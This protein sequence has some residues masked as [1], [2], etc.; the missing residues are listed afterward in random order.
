MIRNKI[1]NNKVKKGC[2]TIY[3]EDDERGT[4]KFDKH[5]EVDFKRRHANLYLVKYLKWTPRYVNPLGVVIESIPAKLMNNYLDFRKDFCNVINVATEEEKIFIQQEV[6]LLLQTMSDNVET[7]TE[8]EVNATLETKTDTLN[9]NQEMHKVKIKTAKMKVE[10]GK[11]M[12]KDLECNENS[13]KVTIEPAKAKQEPHKTLKE[14]KRMKVESE[15]VKKGNLTGKT[16]ASARVY[17]DQTD[18][19]VF[20]IDPQGARVLDDAF[21]LEIRNN[22]KLIGVH[23]ADV[24][25]IVQQGSQI[26]IQA[27][28]NVPGMFTEDENPVHMLPPEIR[29]LCSLLPHKERKV[30]SVYITQ[31]D[32]QHIF[33]TPPEKTVIKSRRQFS[34]QEAEHLIDGVTTACDAVENDLIALSH[35]VSE[36]RRNRVGNEYFSAVLNK[37]KDSP[38]AHELVE[39]LMIQVNESISNSLADWFEDGFPI[40]SHPPFEGEAYENWLTDYETLSRTCL[41]L[42]K[43]LRSRSLGH[44]CTC[45]KECTCSV[46]NHQ[47]NLSGK[48]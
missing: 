33:I 19:K 8:E 16:E 48:V 1:F 20:S 4:I 14:A 43:A 26:D 10:S 13:K 31:E 6:D 5:Q 29:R 35:I 40:R 45:N 44:K 34:Y 30:I 37:Y 25:S 22:E 38:K 7:F 27:Y 42:R 39:E 24:S 15:G 41:P 21:S 3:K 17:K 32:G 46:P 36:M 11:M 12:Q 28:R 18:L 47:N 2:I 9:I 23:L